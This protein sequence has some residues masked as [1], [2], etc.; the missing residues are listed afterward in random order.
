MRGNAGPLIDMTTAV[1]RPDMG[2]A[3]KYVASILLVALLN[4]C[5]PH[6]Y[7]GWVPH[8]LV[9]SDASH[10]SLRKAFIGSIVDARRAG[11][12]PATAA[13]AERTTAAISRLSGS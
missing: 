4:R 12:K 3:L 7:R 10:Y 13:A 11:T 9:H 5:W 8:Q 1:T 6:T 2:D